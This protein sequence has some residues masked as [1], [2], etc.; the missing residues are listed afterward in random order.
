M[1]A[2]LTRDDWG[3]RPRN[4]GGVALREA[5]VE[6]TALHWPGMSSPI[7]AAGEIGQRR[8]ASAL[9]GWQAYHMDVRGWSDIA[10]QA[11]TDQAGRKWRLRGLNVKSGANGNDD[12]NTRFGAILLVLGPGERPSAAMQ[13]T[14]REVVAE[15]KGLFPGCRPKPYGHRDVRPNGTDCP[16][17]LAYLDIQQGDF[18]P[19]SGIPQPPPT[20]DWFDMATKE[21]LDE[22]LKKWTVSREHWDS[23]A[24]A[25]L[26]TAIAAASKSMEGV[27]VTPA[28]VTA[29]QAEARAALS[30][31]EASFG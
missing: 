19:G 1:V 26:A 13:A 20:E 12:V 16:G 2:W 25:Y 6:G 28:M 14:T 7:D 31:L 11:A 27:D 18:T 22:L 3:A 8:V 9:R 30:A 24:W 10:Y 5:N 15:F 4:G 23:Q 17:A 29:A 21:D